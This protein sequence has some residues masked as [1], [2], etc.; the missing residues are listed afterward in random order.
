[1]DEAAD[2]V[3]ITTITTII[4]TI[5]MA[6]NKI[7]T[8]TTEEAIGTEVAAEMAAEDAG[9]M[10]HETQEEAAAAVKDEVITTTAAIHT[11]SRKKA[12]IN[13]MTTT[14]DTI[15]IT[16]QDIITIFMINIRINHEANTMI[17]IT[18]TTNPIA[19]I[20]YDGE[21][22]IRMIQTEQ[23][24]VSKRTPTLISTNKP[25]ITMETGR[26]LIR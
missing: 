21:D 7:D 23:L 11:N 10:T 12:I 2:E 1:M 6:I 4:T 8:I 15:I 25:T 14:M 17:S 24:Y 13:N 5:M 26:K 22:E 3:N 9:D 16:T 18:T 20:E 19:R